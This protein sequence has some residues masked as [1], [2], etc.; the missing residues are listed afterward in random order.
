MSQAASAFPMPFVRD[1]PD[2]SPRFAGFAK[3]NFIGGHNDQA[4]IPIEGL[5]DATASVLRRDGRTLALYNLGHGPQGY[6][7]L[8]AFV[9]EKLSRYRGIACSAEAVLIT[10]GSGQGIDIVSRLLIA[11]GDTVILEEFCYAG[12]INRFAKLGATIV[13]TPLDED[14]IKIDA[15]RARLAEMKAQGVRPKFIYTIPTIQNPTGSILPLERRH[16]LLALAREYDVPIFEDECYADLLWSRTDVPPA[17]YSLDP[18]RVIHIGSFSKS[19][20]PAL[21]V[22]YAVATW[23]VLSR[24]IAAK[25][26]SGTGALDQM[27]IAEF[28]S[29]HFEKHVH[30]LSETLRGKLDTMVEAVERE[31][32]TAAELYLP[33]GGIFLWIRLPDAVDVRKLVKPAAAA[34]VAFNPGPD[35]ACDREASRSHLRLCFALPTKEQ[36]DEGVAAFARV[37]FEETG[38][39]AR[40]DNVTNRAA[41]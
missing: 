27:V 30:A 36:I 24:M 28:F 29:H 12:A 32:G 16:A 31:F 21:R 41:D 11:P 17:L 2:P 13:G 34:G 9:A 26:D 18:E 15:L 8:R 35:W 10:T 39:P 19:L 25:T 37:C 23:P 1:V 6:A 38:I 20:A 40:S 4:K 22:G 14:G 33:K 5:I 7:G 3:Y